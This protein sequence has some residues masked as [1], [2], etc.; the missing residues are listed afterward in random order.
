[1]VL[2]AL[3]AAAAV[4]IAMLPAGFAHAAGITVTPTTLPTA[5]VGTAYTQTLAATG[6]TAPYTW[7][8][9]TGTLPTGLTLSTAGVLAGTPTA[10]GTA[11]VTVTAT[12]ATSTTGTAT[13][14]LIVNAATALAVT[15]TS[16]PDAS[17]GTAYSQTL[18][19]TGGTSPYTWTVT[20]GTL[21]AG[22][23]L[24]SAGVI[25]GT[26]TASG[27]ASVTVTAT[28]AASA[29]ATATLSLAVT[30][31]TVTDLAGSDRFGTAVAV[32][33]AA[34]PTAGSAGAVVL[35]RSDDY[36]DALVG[37]PLAA[38]KNAPLLFTT[39]DTLPTATQT[40]IAR[41]LPAAGTV[42]LLGGTSAI[43]A[44]IA[45]QLSSLGYTV[46]RYG[47]A[48]RYATAV[49]VADAL[50]DPTT[51]LLATGTNFP[52]ALAAGPAATKAGGVVLLTD[53]STLPA[54]TSAYLTAHPG[55]VYAVGGPA[56]AADTTATALA[57]ADRYATAT[58]VATQFFTAPTTIG[59]ASGVTFADA[60]S[61]GAYLAH[62]G[63][64]LVLSDPA[65]LPASTSTY[66]TANAATVTTATLFGGTSALSAAVGT[67]VG[68]ALG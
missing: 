27:T 25:S 48:D 57:G 42:Y 68:V 28:D 54:E 24:S 33:Q 5:T 36:P 23:T 1:M 22:L 43:P 19:A 49:D 20:S 12:D 11:S 62:A 37:A 32:S 60:L 67:A 8:V 44:S 50:S 51:V 66:L 52:D 65:V 14:S 64:P 18:A 15:T 58:A 13:Y 4:L 56:A 29:T 16:L 63:G 17:V 7:A 59:V 45:T 41:V 2:I 61:G 30:S 55:T 38:A 10:S 34:Y 9:T 3:A 21:P 6:G 47:G 40:E 39:G 46:V 35:S 26:P 31:V 53:G